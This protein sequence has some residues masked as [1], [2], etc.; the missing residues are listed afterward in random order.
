MEKKI[1]EKNLKATQQC[2]EPLAGA[3][4]AGLSPHGLPSPAPPGA[5][6]P[7]TRGGIQVLPG[8]PSLESLSGRERQPVHL[9]PSP[10]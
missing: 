1:G 5:P 2:W 4:Q 8:N 9:V 3:G 6:Q 7:P 10:V